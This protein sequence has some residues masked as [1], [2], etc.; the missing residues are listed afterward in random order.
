MRIGCLLVPNGPVFLKCFQRLLR[1]QRCSWVT[2]T[3]SCCCF[4]LLLLAADQVSPQGRRVVSTCKRQSRRRRLS[5]L[6]SH[7]M[8]LALKC[9]GSW[10]RSD[11]GC[12]L[13]ALACR[14]T[15]RISATS[16]SRAISATRRR[17]RSALR[18]CFRSQRI[19]RRFLAGIER[20][21]T[22]ASLAS[23]P[24][25]QPCSSVRGR[26][27]CC[28]RTVPTLIAGI[29]RSLSEAPPLVR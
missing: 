4:C 21:V 27:R 24:T 9:A 23:R 1:T 11:P 12:S 19:L 16:G 18:L 26:A 7:L 13:R 17:T 20:P 3:Y 8:A 29:L 22:A 28:A 5:M 2:P 15:R 14:S 6:F 10:K 25:G